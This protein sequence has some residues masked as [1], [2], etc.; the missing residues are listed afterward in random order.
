MLI[1]KS[2]LSYVRFKIR[3]FF[4]LFKE[5]FSEAKNAHLAKE[6]AELDDFKKEIQV[7]KESILKSFV[8]WEKRKN[9]QQI[10]LLIKIRQQILILEEVNASLSVSKK[11]YYIEML[12]STIDEKEKV[13]N[14]KKSELAEINCS[15]ARLI[16]KL[17]TLS[18]KYKEKKQYLTAV[19]EII[20]DHEIAMLDYIDGI[21]F[22]KYIAYLFKHLGYTNIIRTQ[23]SNDQGLDVIAEKNG[24]RIGIQCKLYS[25]S[26][27]NFAVQ[28]AVTGKTFYKLDKAMIV[29]N[30]FFTESAIKL[31]LG[32]D[33][34]LIDK[35]K[36]NKLIYEVVCSGNYLPYKTDYN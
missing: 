19:Y 1:D 36:L 4:F 25:S 35:G 18:S 33:A 8:G 5:G 7:K 29:T 24:E 2:P 26:V 32:T 11:I 9:I 17:D 22:E 21:E 3:R 34:I 23:D 27:G 10:L 30:N 15:I 16:T 31:G 20:Y 12:D 28:Q 14:N 6:N 13:L